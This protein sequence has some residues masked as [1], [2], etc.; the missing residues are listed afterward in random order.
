MNFKWAEPSDAE[1][2]DGDCAERRRSQF[3]DH[4]LNGSEARKKRSHRDGTSRPGRS[5]TAKSV[6]CH[7]N[8]REAGSAGSVL[9]GPLDMDD[10][11][12]G[13]DLSRRMDIDRK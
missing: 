5:C 11:F 6:F 10:G 9:A 8:D 1:V 12:Q 13:L 3:S 2:V 7:S 4:P